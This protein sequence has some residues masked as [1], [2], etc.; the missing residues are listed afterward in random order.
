VFV[1]SFCFFFHTMLIL[2]LGT[3]KNS[4][5]NLVLVRV[6]RFFWYLIP[7]LIPVSNGSIY[8]LMT[9]TGSLHW[10]ER[11]I[12]HL[13]IG[14]TFL[15]ANAIIS[16]SLMREMVGLK[17]AQTCKNKVIYFFWQNSAELWTIHN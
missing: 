16:Y 17:L 10:N 6:P 7:T 13:L 8:Q 2:M 14:F 11:R 9:N 1:R 3:F 5:T 12:L 15:Q 4:Y